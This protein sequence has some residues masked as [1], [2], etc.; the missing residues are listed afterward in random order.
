MNEKKNLVLLTTLNH[1][2][3]SMSVVL[4]ITSQTNSA[5]ECVSI[6]TSGCFLL[7]C[8]LKFVVPAKNCSFKCQFNSHLAYVL[9]ELRRLSISII[10]KKKNWFSLYSNSLTRFYKMPV[11]FKLCIGIYT[12]LFFEFLP[13]KYRLIIK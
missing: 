9:H 3:W 4:G 13:S 5:V 8:K 7:S 2:R 11:I 10:I 6:N 1:L 12:K